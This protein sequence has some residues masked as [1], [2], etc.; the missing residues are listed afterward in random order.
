V[1][2]NFKNKNWIE[3]LEDNTGCMLSQSRDVEG[4]QK[5]PHDGLKQRVGTSNGT[6]NS[7]RCAA[8]GTSPKARMYAAKVVVVS[9]NAAA[10][11]LRTRRTRPPIYVRGLSDVSVDSMTTWRME[12][13]GLTASEQLRGRAKYSCE[14]ISQL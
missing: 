4:R 1:T 9:A 8:V 11:P 13:P 12:A 6:W 7:T 3:F 14:T 2:E 10:L 5:L